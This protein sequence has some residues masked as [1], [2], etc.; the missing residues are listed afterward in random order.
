MP[1]HLVQG[2]QAHSDATQRAPVLVELFTSEGCS[3]YPP[4]DDLLIRLERAQPVP[5]AEVI[6]LGHHVDYWNRLG[7]TD[8]FSSPAFTARQQDYAD[9]FGN[10]TVYT[11]QMIVDGQAEFVGSNEAR[12]RSAIEA[13]ARLPKATVQV[14]QL[15]AEGSP[16]SLVRF[17][18]RVSDLPHDIG[19]QADVFLAITETN[20][21]TSVARGENTGRTIQHTGV[22]R[23]LARIATMPGQP[24]RP[25]VAEAAVKL[26][27]AWLR[28][29][30]SVVAFLQEPRSRRVLGVARTTLSAQ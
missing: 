21:S 10:N 18:V 3:S 5:G 28:E 9:A 7:W 23:H 13:A 8:R 24:A 20:L 6:A 22:V 17:Q 14:T 30:L 26:K 25:F 12:A 11:P 29:N 4:A 19:G 1:S 16:P 27:S 2:S 15:S